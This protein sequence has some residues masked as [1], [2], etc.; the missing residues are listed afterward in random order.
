M[1]MRD[2]RDPEIYR[3][4]AVRNGVQTTMGNRAADLPIG[5][6]DIDMQIHW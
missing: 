6:F 3:P 5:P 2:A 4:R 1:P